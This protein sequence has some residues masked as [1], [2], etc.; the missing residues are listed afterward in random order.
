MVYS[1]GWLG[2]L[3]V[4]GCSKGNTGVAGGGGI[5]RN[6]VG[7]MI[8]AFASFYDICSNNVAEAKA[9]LQG[10]NMCIDNGCLK[11]IVESDST[12]MADIINR[13]SNVPWQIHN[14]IKQI[15]SLMHR[16]FFL[17]FRIFREGNGMQIRWPIW[18]L[19]TDNT[20][21]SLKIS[22][23]RRKLELH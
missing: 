21:S 20:L 10:T 13:E 11:T 1:R 2:V 9:I 15:W 14:I 22:L 23:C 3:N 8:M 6:H 16:G 12:L 19:Q 4:D 5:I 18:V 7:H 17:F